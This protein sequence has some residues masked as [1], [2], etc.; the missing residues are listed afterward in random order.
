MKKIA[1]LV[2][3]A[4]LGWVIFTG[5][6][7]IEGFPSY[8]KVNL[9]ERVSS[10]YITKSVTTENTSVEYGKSSGMETGSANYVTSIIVNYRS[11]DT[12]GEVTVLFV[13]ALGISLLF[14]SVSGKMRNRFP[15]S[16]ILKTGSKVVFPLILVTG[17][18]IFTHGHLSPG[19]GFPGGSMIASAVLLM[20]LADESF[21]I[22]IERFKRT[23]SLAG[24]FYVIIGLLGLVMTN[25]FLGNFVDT[26]KV[27]SLLSAGI[28]PI[29]YVLVGLKVGSELSGII[30]DF[31]KEEVVEK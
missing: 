31:L 2:F 14:G 29:I 4:L 13:S 1:A 19:G 21:R 17:V 12:L 8:G 16:S 25:Y 27:G 22:R 7:G 6:Y 11:F 20:Y 5:I 15:S 28:I 18:Y 10:E 9:D 26:G 23:E 24:T 3:V 30:T